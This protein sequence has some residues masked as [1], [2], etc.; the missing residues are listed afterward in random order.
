MKKILTTIPFLF[1]VSWVF[2]QTT[3]TLQP[4]ATSGKDAMIW[5]NNPNTNYGTTRDFKA[6][7]W[8]WSGAPGVRRSLIDFDLSGV[9]AG[10]QI[11][12][13]RLSLYFNPNSGDVP[14]TGGHSSLS[15]SNA[16]VLQ[17]IT[18]QWDESTVTWNNQP[19]TTTQNEVQLPQSTSPTQDYLDIDVTAMVEDMIADPSSGGFMIRLQTEQHFRVLLFASSDDLNAALHPKLEITYNDPP[20]VVEEGDTYFDHYGKGYTSHE[21]LVSTPPQ[22][23]SGLN[24]ASSGFFNL[25]FEDVALLNNLGFD[26][27]TLGAARRDVL[28]QV[29]TDLSNLISPS[30]NPCDGSMPVVNIHVLS[31]QQDPT[32]IGTGVLGAASSYYDGTCGSTGTID[33]EVWKTINSGSNSLSSLGTAYHGFVIINFQNT[34]GPFHLDPSLTSV[35]TGMTDLYS[36]VLHEAIHALGFASLIGEFGDSKIGGTSFYGRYDN[37]LVSTPTSSNLLVNQDGCYDIVY[38][39]GL[40]SADLIAGCPNM[41]FDDGLAF[42][43]GPQPV[44]NPAGWSNGSSLSHF[45]FGCGGPTPDYVMHPGIGAGVDKRVPTSVEVQ[46]L[47]NLGY[48][49]TGTF[50]DGSLFFH[51]TGLPACGNVVAGSNDYGFACTNTPY[52]LDFCNGNDQITIDDFLDNDVNAATF[53]CLEIVSGGGSVL[54]TGPDEFTYTATSGG[55]KVLRYIPVDAFG[56]RGNTTCIYIGGPSCCQIDNA[57]DNPCNFVCNPNFNE[58]PCV[59]SNVT[60][61]TGLV[62]GWTCSHGT[63]DRICPATGLAPPNDGFVQMWA[64]QT[65]PNSL[66]EGMIQTDLTFVSGESYTLS[67]YRRTRAHP[68]GGSLIDNLNV[69]LS[70]GVPVTCTGATV[71]AVPAGSQLVYLET[72]INTATWEQVIVHFDALDN[73]S[74]LWIYPEQDPG[75]QTAWMMVDR[76]EIIEDDLEPLQ[77][78]LVVCGADSIELCSPECTVDNLWYEWHDETSGT[79]IPDPDGDGCV[80]VEVGNSYVLHRHVDPAVIGAATCTFN[81]TIRVDSISDCCPGLLLTKEVTNG[82][83]KYAGQNVEYTITVTNFASFAIAGYPITEVFPAAFIPTFIDVDGDGIDDSPF[84]STIDVPATST[85]EIIVIGHYNAVGTYV[86][87][88]ELID[89]N[90]PTMDTLVA[91]DTVTVPLGCP[92][93]WTANTH[94]C[95]DPNCFTHC[96]EFFIPFGETDLIDGIDICIVYDPANVVPCSGTDADVTFDAMAMALGPMVTPGS[97]VLGTTAGGMGTVS[98]SVDY[99]TAFSLKSG[100]GGGPVISVPLC[101]NFRIPTPAPPADCATILYSCGTVLHH[102]S[103]ANTP[104]PTDPGEILFTGTCCPIGLSPDPNWTASP[105][106]DLINDTIYVCP[107][108]PIQFDA[109]TTGGYHSWDF[110]DGTP[111]NSGVESPI[112]IFDTPGYYTVTH[113]V[114]I[115]GFGATQSFVVYVVPGVNPTVSIAATS[116]C[117]MPCN[118]TTDL[119]ASG[120]A[121]P[122]TYDWTGPGGFTSTMEDLSGLCPG[123]YYVT[124]TDDNTCPTT[125]SVVVGT[126]PTPLLNLPDQTVCLDDL[127]AIFDAGSGFASYLWST[128]EMTQTISVTTPGTY[129]V[130]VTTTSGCEV[131]ASADLAV[132]DI[133]AVLV[134]PASICRH[135]EACFDLF[136]TT[137]GGYVSTW[138]FAGGTPSSLTIVGTGPAC[139][140]FNN[141]GMR[142]VSVTLTDTISGCTF[143][144][145]SNVFVNNV[146]NLSLAVDDGDC[147]LSLCQGTAVAS[148]APP[149]GI[150]YDWQPS[151]QTTSTATSLCVGSHTLTVT[152]A[153]GCE[154]E[155]NFTINAVPFPDP[156]ILTTG[157]FCKKDP[158]TFFTAVDGGGVWSGPGISSTGLFKPK[159]VGPGVYVITYTITIPGCG[160]FSDNV[161]IFVYDCTSSTAQQEMQE[162]NG[163]GERY[164]TMPDDGSGY[165]FALFPNPNNGKFTVVASVGLQENQSS[166]QVLDALGRVV[167]HHGQLSEVNEIDI[168]GEAPGVYHVKIIAEERI[169]IQRFVKQ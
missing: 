33:G 21:L 24:C 112:H 92:A 100:I 103:G 136:T 160:S 132:V 84:P 23:A 14:F 4:G 11:V 25:Q 155:Q 145:S 163:A 51:A 123:T 95:L 162:V 69:V 124:V 161:T 22:P 89:I 54:V 93:H 159:K 16:S 42:L 39:P 35:G 78:S 70:N 140:V 53:D 164:T 118:G 104:V 108:A 65:G 156:T 117:P 130:T 129:S 144:T 28:C 138:S 68:T 165:G 9:P 47:C 59:S 168:S 97:Y 120:I 73:Y 98:F 149:V 30:L 147:P 17:R 62:P 152:N 57:L 56:N 139:T 67:F 80:M 60:L 157:P 116:S 106:L 49:T 113:T 7:A 83:I 81:D 88:V 111:I 74:Q 27:P 2:A 134:E 146:P 72:A 66:G 153:D 10:A 1:F 61:A 150:T 31:E 158:P 109:G 99:T 142:N 71:P 6:M 76:I 96:L 77:D 115:G 154:V 143:T 128:G 12:D 36:V 75:G 125:D 44:Y 85:I 41:N 148:V 50:G 52:F 46:V 3:I 169:L 110:G 34:A 90:C 19:A 137:P 86:N 167:Y 38:N 43:P 26:D 82:D 58:G 5:T 37:F 135:A 64:N 126:L 18:S 87:C 127:P 101:F 94:D 122:F 102:Q 29:F 20:A 8:T 79:V 131:N 133:N 55:T 105:I 107:G 40:S 119:T 114:I 141:P 151:G 32:I 48:N 63:P 91:C 13:A 15:G 45:E 121:P 166:L